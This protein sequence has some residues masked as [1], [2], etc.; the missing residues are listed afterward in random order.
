MSDASRPMS[1]VAVSIGAM[2]WT[3]PA[4]DRPERPGV[5]D[6][7]TALDAALEFQRLTFLAKCA[8]LT[9]TQLAE[10]TAGRSTM[11]LLGILR[12]LAGVERWWWRH[13]FNGEDLPM[14]H[15]SDEWPEQDFEDIHADRAEHDYG[16]YVDEV[17]RCRAVVLGRSLDDTFF[18]PG[19]GEL[20]LRWLYLHLI[21]EYARHNG[22]ADILRE[23]ID[24]AWASDLRC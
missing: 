12:H 9:G 7:R 3:A 4:V 22:H 21:E 11:S 1:V 8:G 16:G 5:A 15:F 14:L 19:R 23:N 13:W 6:E 24:G 18:R 17:E 2:A 20:D 10:R